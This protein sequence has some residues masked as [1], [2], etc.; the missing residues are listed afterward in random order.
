[1]V[2]LT[3][4]RELISVDDV[5]STLHFGPNGALVY[6][7]EYLIDN[8]EWLT[9]HLDTFLED[10]YLLVDCPGQIELY[11]H[12]PVMRHVA[13]VFRD[14]GF[15][16]CGVYCVD[17]LFLTDASKF[18][19]GNLLALAAMVHLELPHVNVLTKCDLVDA[20]VMQRYLSPDGASLVAELTRHTPERFKRMNQSIAKLV[21][22]TVVLFLCAWGYAF[23]ED[24]FGDV[25]T[26][27]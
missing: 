14:A 21:R 17:A 20:D 9:D 23:T 3:D 4:I 2:C 22:V 12:I 24:C 18:I 13:R 8:L 1:M 25:T 10:D 11:S 5:M 15:A 16:V 19:A 26:V 27:G 6:C 7:M